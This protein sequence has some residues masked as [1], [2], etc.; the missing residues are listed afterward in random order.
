MTKLFAPFVSPPWKYRLGRLLAAMLL[1][2][3]IWLGL[4]GAPRAHASDPYGNY[5][6]VEHVD[7]QPAAAGEPERVAIYGVFA[8]SYRPKEGPNKDRGIYSDPKDGYL[9]FKCPAD[10]TDVCR[11]EWADLKRAI[12][13]G[14]CAAFGDRYPTDPNPN[15]RLRAYSE[16]PSDPDT[17][18]IGRGVQLVEKGGYDPSSNSIC[19]SLKQYRLNATPPPG[20]PVDSAPPGQAFLP[21]ANTTS[22]EAKATATAGG[23]VNPA[24]EANSDQSPPSQNGGGTPIPNSISVLA[25]VGLVVLAGGTALVW[26]RGGQKRLR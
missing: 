21:N 25:L 23:A 7:V 16:A 13:S 14:K 3:L 20:A 18:P 11:M 10:K 15:G 22:T 1:P 4:P 24:I 26:M 5:A 17:Y 12:G 19:D 6:L 8:L 9:Y 2:A